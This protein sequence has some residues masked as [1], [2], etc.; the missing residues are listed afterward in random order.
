MRR[1]GRSRFRSARMGI[2]KK[3]LK[4]IL[5]LVWKVARI[6]LWKWLKPRLRKIAF[7]T[8]TVFVVFSV[9]AVLVAGS[10]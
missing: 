9:L 3:V 1:D 7:V 10:C 6:Y 8:V 4:E 2:V 5:K